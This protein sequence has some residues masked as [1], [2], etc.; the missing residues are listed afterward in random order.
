[1]KKAKQM[2]YAP[3]PANMRSTSPSLGP[4]PGVAGM[5]S[6]RG[7]SPAGVEPAAPRR[8]AP[9]P[10]TTKVVA[11]G[12]P[13]PPGR[14]RDRFISLPDELQGDGQMV[15][16]ELSPTI[17]EDLPGLDVEA[18]TRGRITVYCIA[19]SLDRKALELRLR[20]RGGSALL[21][22]YPDVLYGLYESAKEG[23]PCRGEC[24][25]FDYGAVAFWGLSERQE[26]EV[27][28]TLL[29]PCLVDDL[30]MSEVEV[31]E[32]QFHYSLNE[33]PHIQ[34]DTITINLRL[35]SD[36][37][38]KLSISHALA[39]SA[40]LS[41][42]EERVIQIVEST[43]DLPEAL[44]ATGEVGLTRKQIARMI[45]RVFIQ[46]SAVNLLSTVLD[47]PEFFWSAPDSMQNLYKRVCEY[48]EYDT[49]VEV[50][51]NR[52]Q[53]LQEMLDM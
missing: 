4:P 42:Y 37:L 12:Q 49:R 45:G 48:M 18:G 33:K 16:P 2:G 8:P 27:L 34:N 36:H 20:E 39:Q 5:L 24:F 11:P 7:A 50:L 30:E 21:H 46:K 14:S 26:R 53:V 9:K 6:R 41:V 32:F 29:A 13:A 47:T 52:F 38:I 3:L 51:N 44:A 40:K 28:R 17:F 15:V 43:K 31:D 35:R 19:E 22:Q 10:S 1:M 25:Y 23:E